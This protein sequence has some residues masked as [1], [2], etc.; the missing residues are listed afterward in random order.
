[1]HP[2]IRRTLLVAALLFLAFRGWDFL[3]DPGGGANTLPGRLA[4]A[5]LFGVSYI[6]VAF[7]RTGRRYVGPIYVANTLASPFLILWIALQLPDGF[8]L[9]H[10]SF[11]A[12]TVVA[13]VIGP[14]LRVSVPLVLSSLAV[15]NLGVLVLLEAG[16]QVPGLPGFAEAVNLALIH[17]AVGAVAVVLMLVHDRLQRAMLADNVQLAQLAGTDPLTG[18]L[19]RRQLQVEFE[20]E[21]ARQR[22]HEKPS[23][24][25]ELDID[26]FKRVNDTHGHD[27]GDEVL[28][29]LARRWR[30][31]IREV[32][33]LARVGGEEF[34]I[35]L[36][37][38]DRDGT[39]ELA[40]RVRNGTE[41]EPVST[42]VGPLNVTVSIGA[43]LFTPNER[44]LK[45]LISRVDRALYQAKRG[46]RN[47]CEF[48]E[49]ND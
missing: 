22:R 18:L 29:G 6:V 41:S 37:E 7:T 13:M 49:A 33:I 32:D 35:L 38:T 17:A 26:H 36:P 16:M 23:G 8:I 10:S 9:A 46:G 31:T 27:V 48:V 34:V 11:L 25:L 47:R 44:G 45:P 4:A 1:V 39:L 40:E 2:Y 12:V 20:R 43:S 30:S 5:A 42:S 3:V 15:P 21:S 24:V 28:L 14:T 19:N